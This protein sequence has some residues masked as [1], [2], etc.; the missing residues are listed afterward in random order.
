MVASVAQRW[1]QLTHHRTGA[2]PRTL[3]ACSGGADS[4]A[5]AIAM[6]V[7]AGDAAPKILALAHIRHDMRPDSEVEADANAVGALSQSFGL[8]VM[9]ADALAADAPRTEATYRKL[10]YAALAQLA[11]AH[12]YAFVATAHHADDQLESLLLAL[13][14]GAGPAG[15]RGIAP[16][17]LI[18]HALPRIMLIRP[19]L[20]ASHADAIQL[21]RDANVD[22][23]EDHTNVDVTRL[24]TAL[25]LGP[26][27]E[28][29][30]LVPTAGARAAHTASLMRN[31]VR[32]LDSLADDAF[33]PPAGPWSRNNL[34]TLPRI[35][36][37]H[38]L[39]RALAHQSTRG[40]DRH[41]ARALAPITRAIR[42]NAGET[43][44]FNL[45]SDTVVTVTSDAVSISAN[46]GHVA[47][48]G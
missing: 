20:G 6:A 16:R 1:R 39:R 38:G 24:R 40:H 12:G 18:D 14:R 4:S 48:T 19:M 9:H 23:S 17:R 26:V 36:L 10:R 32:L 27:D 30:Q 46:P 33:Q 21:C 31:V 37:S 2:L 3:I 35:V 22:W 47:T 42:S 34:R 25:R 41:T 11:R 15:L 28:L 8:P 13:T 43:R 44:T 45:A 7:I 29:L 5:L